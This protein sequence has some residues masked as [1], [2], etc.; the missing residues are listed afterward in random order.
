M[1]KLALMVHGGAWAIPDEAVEACRAGCRRALERG[2][3]VLET[4]GSAL[5]ACAQAIVELENDPVFDAGVGAH[6]NRDGR[7]QLDAILMDGRTLESGAVAAVERLRNPIQVAR[8]VLE[9][10]EHMLLVGPG[11]EQFAVEMG[12]LRCNPAELVVAREVDA[13]SQCKEQTGAGRGPAQNKPPVSTV[14]AVGL[15]A[16]G[17]LAAGTSTGGTMCKYPGRVGDSALVGCG[18]YADNGTGAISTTGY[19]EAIMKVVL[20]KAAS[21]LLAA[22]REPPAAAEKAVALLW[23]RTQGQGGLILV[24]RGGRVAFAFTTPRMALAFRT[25]DSPEPIVRV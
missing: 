13:W 6:L 11:A 23:E 9:R 16:E 22:G 1:T 17:N 15:D 8:L 21:D 19:G 18:C 7:V 3:A 5:D 12:V 10:S 2:W 25:S 20:A 24:D 4:G 14:G